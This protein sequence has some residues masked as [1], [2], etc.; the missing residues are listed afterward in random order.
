[1]RRTVV[2]TALGIVALALSLAVVP[3]G[4]AQAAGTWT[5]PVTSVVI[6]GFEPP[7]SPFGPG[8]RGIDI[9]TPAGTPVLAAD[10]GTVTFAGKVGGHMFVTID[11]GGGLESTYSWLSQITVA[12]ND[13]VGSGQVIAQSG[14]GHPGVVPEHLHFGA[15][16]NDVYVDPLDYLAPGDVVDLIRL[17]PLATA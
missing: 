11:H 7:S 1:M 14:A 9:A 15:R 4:V 13:V 16:L 2:S 3:G 6:H 10:A 17:A 12:K 8:H 5:W